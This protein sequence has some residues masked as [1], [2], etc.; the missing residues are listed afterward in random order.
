M[1]QVDRPE[2]SESTRGCKESFDETLGLRKQGWLRGLV[3]FPKGMPVPHGG[4][5]EGT[6]QEQF[7][8]SVSGPGVGWGFRNPPVQGTESRQHASVL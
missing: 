6:A 2:E 7:C 1:S 4:K 3:C 5:G 8:G